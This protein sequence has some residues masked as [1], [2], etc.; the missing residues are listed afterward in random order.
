MENLDAIPENDVSGIP[1]STLNEI[2]EKLKSNVYTTKPA[3]Y[4]P[5]KKLKS[6][7]WDVFNLV[8]YLRSGKSYPLMVKPVK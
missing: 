3:S 4:H 6:E 2:Q 7:V 1:R 5:S 8:E